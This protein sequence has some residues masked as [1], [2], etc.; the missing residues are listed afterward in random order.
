MFFLLSKT[1][2]FLTQ[3]SNCLILLGLL[4]LVLAATR[5]RR[6]GVRLMG[7]AIALLAIGGW[8]PLAN[9]LILPL[10]ERF[11]PW[12][13]SRGPPDGIIV[14]GGAVSPE[15]SA[16]REE[17]QLNEAAERVAAMV[18]L[19]RQ[20]PNARLVYSG[21]SG[22]LV[23]NEAMEADYALDLL[24]RLGVPRGRV[25]IERRSRNTG[26]NAAFTKALV[27]PKPGE[28]WLLVTSAAHMPRSVGIF[29]RAEFAVEAYPVDWRTRGAGDVAVPFYALSGGLA[30]LD[31]AL[32]EWVGLVAYRLAGR[33]AELFPGPEVTAPVS[34]DAAARGGRRP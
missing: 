8:S 14:L 24:E 3:P 19:A 25:Q 9:M 2:G 28:R 13:A 1:I 31:T 34:R 4:G 30:R 6:A 10:E 15:V 16:R 18:S 5:F 23:F 7:I 21:G 33:T 32:H 12:D 26:E 17:P 27:Q 29:R 20:Y 11:P 22:G